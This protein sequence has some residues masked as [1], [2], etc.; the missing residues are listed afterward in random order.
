MQWMMLQQPEPKDY[1]I[2]TGKQHSVRDF[3]SWS[4]SELGISLRFKG[5]GVDEIGIVDSIDSGVSNCVSVGDVIV[6]IDPSYF[7]PS[8]VSSLLGDSSKA[9][10]DLG[11]KP[12]ITAQEMCVEMVKN[13]FELAI[14]SLNYKDPSRSLNQG[15]GD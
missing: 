3:V 8:D 11:W 6:R 9:K 14:A 13:D 1:V 5:C 12:E 10:S 7:R 15:I 2:A 4:A